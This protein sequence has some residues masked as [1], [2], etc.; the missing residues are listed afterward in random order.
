Y[1]NAKN[2]ISTFQSISLIKPEKEPDILV[3]DSISL[4][5]L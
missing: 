5:H 4:C 2:L 3:K 1:K